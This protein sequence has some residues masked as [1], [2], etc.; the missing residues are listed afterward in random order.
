MS[1]LANAKLNGVVKGLEDLKTEFGEYK[2]KSRSV[3]EFLRLQNAEL[4]EQIEDA[5]DKIEW[6]AGSLG[7]EHAL[8][9]SCERDAQPEDDQGRQE[10]QGDEVGSA[11]EGLG[12]NDGAV[13]AAQVKK[14]LEWKDAKVIR[15]VINASMKVHLGVKKLVPKDLPSYPAGF[16]RQ[17]DAWPSDETGAKLTRFDC[18]QKFEHATNQEAYR[19]IM[20]HV[21]HN[22]PTLF[23]AAAEGLR[24]ILEGDLADRVE[25]RVKY[26]LKGAAAAAREAG[27]NHVRAR[28]QT[29]NGE[30]GQDEDEDGEKEEEE[31]SGKGALKRSQKNA[32]VAS[33]LEQRERKREG[34][35]YTDEKYNSA[36]T[37]TAMSDNDDDP[38][39]EDGRAKRY[40]S[41]APD[42]RSAMVQTL[43]DEIDRR[44]DP[45]PD[46]AKIMTDRVRGDVLVNSEPPKAK[47]LAMKIRVWQV[48]DE[49]L[50]A[51][52]HWLSNGRIAENG[53]LW[54]DEEDPVDID[55]G[56][57]K[58]KRVEAKKRLNAIG[59]GRKRKRQ[60]QGIESSAK[61]RTSEFLA[62]RDV[63]ALFEL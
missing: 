51:N 63:T 57:A 31:Q 59:K 40:I 21:K 10:D 6:L 7:V 15:D 38:A 14:S 54:G 49:K 42:F 28:A 2:A 50:K 19:E 46:K 12:D 29:V 53:V 32:R 23:P 8:S 47:K 62:G 44:H 3:V 25:Q 58:A 20:Q 27:T 16:D 43:Y 45:N 48:A 13:S 61:V 5:E 26:M 33:K 35:A 60:E 17:N 41:H 36:F 34:S 22:G 1:N 4:R 39:P 37:L 18:K 55:E 11:D 56:K 9:T 24:E 52:P 30:D